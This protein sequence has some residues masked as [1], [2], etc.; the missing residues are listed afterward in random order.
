M[1]EQTLLLS[2]FIEERDRGWKLPKLERK[3]IVQGHCHHKSIMRFEAE[4]K[5]LSQMGIE[6]NHL[7]SGCCGMAGGFGFERDKYDVSI[8]AGERVLLPAVR[9]T[10]KS[11]IVMANGFSCREQITQRSD[12][13]ALHL[14]E[15][16]E[17][18]MQKGPSG[19]ENGEYPES[20]IVEMR[21]R[22]IKRSMLRAGIFTGVTALAGAYLLSRRRRRRR[23]FS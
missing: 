17:L 20:H 11:T 14:A 2:E 16:I 23:L 5:V 6:A 15:V 19:S 7:T 9:E 12:R 18:A 4:R 3:A 21:E 8:G 22:A 1:M 13:H 10:P